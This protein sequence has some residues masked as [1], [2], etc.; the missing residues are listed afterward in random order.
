MKKKYVLDANIL[1]S[2]FIGGKNIYKVL[3]TQHE[4]YVPDFI[5]LEI[6]KYEEIILKRRRS[7]RSF[8]N[9]MLST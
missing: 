8:S 6:E 3:F 4:I 2:A 9:N 5:F 1:F 7:K